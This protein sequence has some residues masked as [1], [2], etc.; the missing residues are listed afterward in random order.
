VNFCKVF[1]VGYIYRVSPLDTPVVVYG[2]NQ[3]MIC[4]VVPQPQ[5]E[6]E[7]RRPAHLPVQKLKFICA[8]HRDRIRVEIYPQT[9]LIAARPR[10]VLLTIDAGIIIYVAIQPIARPGQCCSPASR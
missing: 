1:G 7:E 2:T 9:Q 5:A 10:L 8:V 4:A 3:L 6:N